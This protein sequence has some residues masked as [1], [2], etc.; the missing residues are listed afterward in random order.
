MADHKDRG[1]A[2]PSTPDYPLEETLEL[3]DPTQY[4]ALFE[5]TRKEIVSLLL[6]RAATTSELAEVLSRPKGTVGHH[7]KVL[8][9]AGLVHV[10]RTKQVRAIQAKYYGR[11]ARVFLY[12]RE[13]E[14]VGE[15]ER[16]LARA[17][18]GVAQV[19]D[20]LASANARRARIPQERAHEWR[21]RLDAL[22]LEFASEPVAGDTTFELVYGLYA[23]DRRPLPEER[24]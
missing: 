8:E 1:V 19:P 14:A 4:R 15:E 13:H 3:T 20:G 2:P 17:A 12:R 16:V 5:E 6:E 10:V 7:L 21:E 24:Q 9:E 18:A 23:T 22:L 11:T